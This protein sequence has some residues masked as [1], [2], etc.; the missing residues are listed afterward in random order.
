MAPGALT[1]APVPGSDRLSLAARSPQTGFI[2]ESTLSG[3]TGEA[4]ARAGFAAVAISGAAS[5]PSYLV[6][7]GDT[8]AVRPTGHIWRLPISEAIAAFVD[9]LPRPGFEFLAI[10]PAG[11]NLVRF[12]SI[13]DRT[14]R[15]AGRTGLGAVM[16]SKNLKGV[17]IRG[18]GV[19]PMHDPAGLRL[20]MKD[21]AD[22][23]KRPEVAVYGWSD[24]IKGVS[25]LS[26]MG[27][28][29]AA[30]FQRSTG[31]MTYQVLGDRLLQGTDKLR[32]GCIGCPVK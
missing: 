18:G 1:G 11:E 19:V 29:P 32:H 23:L 5:S 21:L 24:S 25:T 30:N 20:P 27:A 9:D 8:V 28:L 3:P 26:R 16:G 13:A 4:L 14:G 31:D 2:G 10:G 7:D 12:A 6:V 15:V 17:A 22:R